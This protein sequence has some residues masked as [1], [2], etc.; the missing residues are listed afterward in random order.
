MRI[1]QS[2]PIH[3]HHQFATSVNSRVISRHLSAGAYLTI[4]GKAF[5]AELPITVKTQRGLGPISLAETMP[6][7]GRIAQNSY[8]EQWL[9]G[10]ILQG[11][12]ARPPTRSGF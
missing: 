2:L 7:A 10:S 3:L 5:P 12:P 4:T 8:F 1:R 11:W 9:G 6:A